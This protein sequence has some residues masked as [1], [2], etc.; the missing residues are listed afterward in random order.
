[1]AKDEVAKL[2]PAISAVEV[3]MC[4]CWACTIS[5][6]QQRLAVTTLE[7]ANFRVGGGDVLLS[8]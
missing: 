3:Q 1:M 8:T 6:I 4:M 7:V 5:R 2:H